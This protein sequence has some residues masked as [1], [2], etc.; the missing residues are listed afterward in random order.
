[1]NV[2]PLV[3]LLMVLV[4]FLLTSA[5]AGVV[6]TLVVDHQRLSEMCAGSPPPPEPPLPPL[7][8]H[9]SATWIWIGRSI[10]S[11]ER[12]PRRTLDEERAEVKRVVA[13][14]RRLHPDERLVVIVVDDGESY[15]ELV[16]TLTV[17][18]THGYERSILGGGPSRES[19]RK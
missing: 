7:T 6:Q 10:D 9:V 19:V 16:M 18:R 11:G 17:A 14:D 5:G 3:D 13:A 4:V 1:M 2:V 8:V 15:D 12:I